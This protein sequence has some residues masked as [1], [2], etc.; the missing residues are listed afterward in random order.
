MTGP[1]AFEEHKK[2][3]KGQWPATYLTSPIFRQAW[4]AA[5]EAGQQAERA[6]IIKDI[7]R[8][9]RSLRVSHRLASSVGGKLVAECR[10]SDIETCGRIVKQIQAAALR[11]EAPDG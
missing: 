1:E 10:Q 11:Q 5:W 4:I 8:M 9:Q 6:E 7:R 3:M 2:A